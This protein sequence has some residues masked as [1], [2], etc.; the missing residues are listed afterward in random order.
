MSSVSYGIA[1]TSADFSKTITEIA[2]A[3]EQYRQRFGTKPDTLM[4]KTADTLH[5]GV[6]AHF[7]AIGYTIIAQTGLV[8]A[9]TSVF[10]QTRGLTERPVVTDDDN[11]F[12]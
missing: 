10:I 11:F 9:P 2:H 12:Y 8:L 4:T 1:L 5:P 6:R 3:C 7:Q